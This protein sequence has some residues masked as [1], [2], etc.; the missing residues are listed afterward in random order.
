MKL[1]PTLVV[2]TL[3]I[4]HA[5][6]LRQREHVLGQLQSRVRKPESSK[7]KVT[8]IISYMDS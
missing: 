3:N 8:I 5:R 2:D 1:V 6:E 4:K 7:D